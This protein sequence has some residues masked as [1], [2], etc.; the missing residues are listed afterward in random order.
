M[1][2]TTVDTAIYGLDCSSPLRFQ[3]NNNYLIIIDENAVCVK[4]SIVELNA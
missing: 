4:W 3:Y 1:S 2:D